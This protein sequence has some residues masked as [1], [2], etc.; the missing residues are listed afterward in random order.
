MYAKT[1]LSFIQGL[2]PDVDRKSDWNPYTSAFAD[3]RKHCHF[4]EE[5]CDAWISVLDMPFALFCSLFNVK[6]KT[7]RERS[8]A[9]KE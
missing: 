1:Y 3:K 2:L 8:E 9:I 7:V 4:F 5:G 6:Q